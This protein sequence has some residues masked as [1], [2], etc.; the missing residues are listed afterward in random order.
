[1]RLT[2]INEE[3]LQL[4]KDIENYEVASDYYD[5]KNEANFAKKNL[6]KIK[7]SIKL[8]NN[9]EDQI[10]R[11]LQLST[12]LQKESIEKI[13]NEVNFY[14]PESISKRLEELESFYNSLKT[15]RLTRLTKQRQSIINK[16]QELEKRSNAL[17][18]EFDTK[19]KYLGDHKALDVVLQVKDKLS[20]LEKEKE[21]LLEALVVRQ[22]PEGTKK[23]ESDPLLTEELKEIAR[24]FNNLSEMMSDNGE[25]AEILYKFIVGALE[26]TNIKYNNDE[27]EFWIYFTGDHY[28][29]VDNIK[30]LG[31]IAKNKD[32]DKLK[33]IL[34][35]TVKT[36]LMK[37]LAN[38]NQRLSDIRKM[39]STNLQKESISKEL[40]ELESDPLQQVERVI[41]FRAKSRL[42]NNKK[43]SSWIFGTPISNNQ[44]MVVMR[45]E[46]HVRFSILS[47]TLGQFIGLHDKR[48]KEIYE[49]DIFTV[50][51]KYPK[52][53]VYREE[54]AAFCLVNL[55][56]IKNA[57]WMDIYQ[58]PHISWW[59]D[60]AKCIEII[61]N[62]HDNPELLRG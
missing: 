47:N 52:L 1:M 50:N 11:S 42:I 25:I 44:D 28:I 17:K 37:D 13:Y 14:F 34:K 55:D 26:V 4:K 61:G 45:N 24:R 32:Y 51:G 31:E 46:L 10:E 22:S 15:N 21:S 54:I 6:D 5:I 59:K 23:L 39:L 38:M 29:R 49:G 27:N 60:H 7:N 35:I 19:M 33:D 8:L 56:D 48:G 16:R 36:E 30:D 57:D 12:D 62:K 3:I 40:E 18:K 53:V 9:Q 43:S 20:D 58:N 2:D 41:K